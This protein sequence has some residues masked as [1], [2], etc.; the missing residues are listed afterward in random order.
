[1]NTATLTNGHASLDALLD[2]SGEPF[3]GIPETTQPAKRKGTKAPAA[4]PQVVLAP[5]V[6]TP[7]PEQ[8]DKPQAA[9]INLADATQE[10]TRRLA[11]SL[12]MPASDA[13]PSPVPSCRPSSASTPD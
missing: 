8:Q 13:E 1:M 12:G 2:M 6:N 7:A 10:L 5:V 9:I 11:R 4:A 3:A